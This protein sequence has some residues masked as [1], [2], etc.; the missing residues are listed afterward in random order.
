KDIP[1]R[2]RP[3][4]HHTPPDDHPAVRNQPEPP[5]QASHAAN[6]TTLDGPRRSLV[7]SCGCGNPPSGALLTAGAQ[8]DRCELTQQSTAPPSIANGVCEPVLGVRLVQ[9]EPWRAFRT[10]TH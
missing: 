1:R 9:G 7:R 6:S 3:S 10:Q 5:P 8:L 2:H 4:R